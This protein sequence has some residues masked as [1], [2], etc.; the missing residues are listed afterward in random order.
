MKKYPEPTE[1][2]FYWGSYKGLGEDVFR[3]EFSICNRAGRAKKMLMA[4]CS[5]APSPFRLYEIYWLSDRLTPPSE[6]VDLISIE[7]ISTNN[8]G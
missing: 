7:S 4:Y 6:M 1:P 2:G 8:D 5:K 3:V